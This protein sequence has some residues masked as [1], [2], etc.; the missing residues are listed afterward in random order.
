VKAVRKCSREFAVACLRK[1]PQA[2]QKL[3]AAGL[4]PQWVREL[5]AALHVGGVRV[6]TRKDAGLGPWWL[7]ET[8]T[9]GC[10]SSMRL[11]RSGSL[12]LSAKIGSSHPDFDGC[13]SAV[14]AVSTPWVQFPRVVGPVGLE[15]TTY[16]LKIWLL[17]QTSVTYHRL[18]EFPTVKGEMKSQ[19]ALS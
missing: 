2:I 5:R 12:I 15:P 3:A 9:L 11:V 18:A 6:V 13:W 10:H 4:T 19:I 14:L 8:F 7:M 16:G 17:A 1:A